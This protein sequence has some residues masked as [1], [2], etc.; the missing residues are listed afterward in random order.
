MK[1]EVIIGMCGIVVLECVNLVTLRYDGYALMTAI[2]IIAGLTGYKY[3]QRKNNSYEE[4]ET[5]SKSY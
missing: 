1:L 4:V 5:D 2:S 3:G